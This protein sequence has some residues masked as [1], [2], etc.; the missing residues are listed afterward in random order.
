MPVSCHFLKKKIEIFIPG[1]ATS[2]RH[3]LPTQLK[4]RVEKRARV[5]K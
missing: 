2:R 5:V 3:S 4:R 1:I